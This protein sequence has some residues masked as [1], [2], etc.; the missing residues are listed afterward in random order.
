MPLLL[1]DAIY[2]QIDVAAYAAAAGFAFSLFLDYAALHYCCCRCRFAFM[3]IFA[4]TASDAAS[5]FRRC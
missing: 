2:F 1:L 5:I 4:A 3:P